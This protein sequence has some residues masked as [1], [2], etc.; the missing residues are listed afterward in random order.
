MCK[1]YECPGGPS[2]I[3][4]LAGNESGAETERTYNVEHI[5][6][7]IMVSSAG[8]DSRRFIKST[9]G[10]V[11]ERKKVKSGSNTKNRLG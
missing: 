2:T 7:K 6:T 5:T 8:L 3:A 4:C 10:V 9:L 11:A 1:N